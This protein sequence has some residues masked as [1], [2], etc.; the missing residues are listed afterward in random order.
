MMTYLKACS[1]LLAIATVSFEGARGATAQ[2]AVAGSPITFWASQPVDPGQTVMLSGANLAGG[3][4]VRVSALDDSAPGKPVPLAGQPDSAWKS[5][6]GTQ[7]IKPIQAAG[8]VLQFILPAGARERV[9]A[10][11]VNVAGKLSPVRLINAPDPWF[12]QGDQGDSASPGGWIGVFGTCIAMPGGQ[13]TRLALVS[14]DA[15]VRELK[16]R[17]IGGTDYG[18]YFDIPASM[19]PGAYDLY[20]HNGH[21]GP[22]AWSHVAMFGDMPISTFSIGV[23]APWPTTVYDVGKEAGPTD[24]DRFAQAIQQARSGGIISIPAGTYRLT[25]P[26]ALP[27]LVTLRGAGMATT[28]LEWTADPTDARGNVPL[29]RGADIPMT[30]PGNRRA[31][32]SLEDLAIHAS[33]TFTG[34]VVDRS[35]TTIPAHFRRVAI[36][37]F[38]PSAGVAINL[39]EC[40]NTEIT[41]CDLDARGGISVWGYISS[42]RCTGTTIR[43][44]DYNVM[45]ARQWHGVIFEHNKLVM[46]GTFTGNGFTTAQNPNPGFWYCGYDGTNG[47]DCYF[48]HNTSTREEAEPPDRC[49][50]ITFDGDSGAYCGKITAVDGTNLTL[51]GQTRGKD[52]YNHQPTRP[53]AVVMIISGRGAGEWRYLMT[54]DTAQVNQ[55]QIDRPWDVQPDNNSWVSICNFLGHALFVDNQFG[56]EALLQT[57]FGPHDVVWAGNTIGVPGKRV[58]MP[59]WVDAAYAGWH[60]QVLDNRITDLGV[61]MGTAE[62]L[63]QTPKDY[64]GPLAQTQIYR[65]N[66]AAD[67]AAVFSISVPSRS[68]GFLIEDNQG[69][70]DISVKGTKDAEGVIRHN[71]GLHGAIVAPAPGDLPAHADGKDTLIFGAL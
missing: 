18:Q 54:A 21:G 2:G 3:A 43:W 67:P 16:A 33:P 48:A 12:A 41:D 15:V 71:T 36:K 23:P 4:V 70:A 20:I 8:A 6:A 17:R 60:Y 31:S 26:L 53:G 47:R 56:N 55:V 45:L 46:A 10:C 58:G 11:R 44:R 52:Q 14:G 34:T 68:L 50:G 66:R 32:F 39:S 25:R 9:Y 19:P 49:I 69:M 22:H 40:R 62:P 1:V 51:A 30:T 65:G 35:G 7:E 64:T 63:W 13:P 57:Y 27:N 24:D 59:V 28:T 61:D 42:L 37:A 38:V 5:S 29:I